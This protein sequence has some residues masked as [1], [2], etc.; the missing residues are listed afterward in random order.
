MGFKSINVE[1]TK[2]HFERAIKG[3]P[4]EAIK[5]LLQNACDADAK[6]IEVSFVFDG[7]FGVE[8]VSDIYIKDDGHGI[9]YDRAEEYF[10]KYGR[11][12][13]T[14]ADKSPNGRVYHG[15][16]GQGRY[17]SLAAGNFVDWETVFESDD[18]N[19][20]TYQI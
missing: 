9:A 14:Y 13:K 16:L 4:R 5:E 19:L 1:L 10:G 17:K 2:E 18:K 8:M 7:L 20:Y 3:S 11:S 15:K 12:Q 6:N